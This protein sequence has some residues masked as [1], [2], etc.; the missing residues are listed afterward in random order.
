MFEQEIELTQEIEEAI[1]FYRELVEDATTGAAGQEIRTE[2]MESDT[3]LILALKYIV[4]DQLWENQVDMYGRKLP[5]YRPSTIQKKARLGHPADKLVN[6]TER[7]TGRFY[8]EGIRVVVDAARDQYS[9]ENT[10]ALD[11][12]GYIP[13][14]Y[15]GMTE[16]NFDSYSSLM[17][18][19]VE[20]EQRRYINRRVQESQYSD[21]LQG[22]M[23]IGYDFGI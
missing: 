22:L 18:L 4:V 6:Y 23:F 10:L 14:E 19:E 16:E 3:A 7:W 2:V 5:Q 8:N 17:S 1:D 15:I 9:F 20:K 11:Y 13:D 21:I 12:F